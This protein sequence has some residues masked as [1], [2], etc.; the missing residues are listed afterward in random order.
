MD[1]CADLDKIR[2]ERISEGLAFFT[3]SHCSKN[4]HGENAKV[5]WACEDEIQ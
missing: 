5:V 3:M 4:D 1:T 2:N